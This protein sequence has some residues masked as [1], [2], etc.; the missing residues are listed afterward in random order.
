MRLK[1]QS[2]QPALSYV[3]IIIAYVSINVSIRIAYVSIRQPELS[4]PI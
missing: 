4:V 2:G 3:S 1:R